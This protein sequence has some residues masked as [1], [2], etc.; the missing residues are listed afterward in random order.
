MRQDEM[1]SDGRSVMH[2]QT[3]GRTTDG[4]VSG[5]MPSSPCL[6]STGPAPDRWCLR[7]P[8]LADGGN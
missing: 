8:T 6:L 2:L 5:L 3:L 7:R 4:I 1:E